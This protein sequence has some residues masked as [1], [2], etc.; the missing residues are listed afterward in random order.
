MPLSSIDIAQRGICFYVFNG[1]I[2]Y[3]HGE[4]GHDNVKTLVPGIP[5]HIDGRI[6]RF[7]YVHRDSGLVDQVFDSGDVRT[8]HLVRGHVT[9][10]KDAAIT[11][12]PFARWGIENRIPK[13]SF[14]PELLAARDPY[15]LLLD[16]MRAI[17]LD[18]LEP[19][20]QSK[21][22]GIL[23]SLNKALDRP[24][25][26]E[27]QLQGIDYEDM[28]CYIAQLIAKYKDNIWA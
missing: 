2:K 10:V 5:H 20:E 6:F 11:I 22:T 4:I 19:Y 23:Q 21:L 13:H 17:N 3:F 1:N 16:E 9:S 26:E 27:D 24:S 18:L 14:A 25:G 7:V 12:N 28:K 8:L 15:L